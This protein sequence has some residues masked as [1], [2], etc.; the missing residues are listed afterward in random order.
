MM[1]DSS[2]QTNPS[3]TL[4][5]ANVAVDATLLICARA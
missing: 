5:Q 4:L 1:E 2:A 3:M